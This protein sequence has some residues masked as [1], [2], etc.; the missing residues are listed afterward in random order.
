MPA[1]RTRDTQSRTLEVTT[2]APQP[3]ALHIVSPTPR[4]FTFPTSH[5]L[6][7]SPYSSPSN[8][9][10]EPDH[11]RSFPATCT[12]DST[13]STLPSPSTSTPPPSLFT[14]T[15]TPIVTDSPVTPTT[16]ASKR[17][18]STSS[19]SVDPA[20]RRPKKGDE[21]YVK[22]PENAFILFRRQCCEDRQA[23]LD[24]EPAGGVA[25]KKQRQAD[26][27][28]TISQ[29]W[30]SLSAGERKIW[31]DKAALKKREHEQLHPGYVYRPQRAKDKDG[32]ARNKKN[33]IA[34]AIA[35]SSTAGSE[36]GPA[37]KHEFEA[38]SLTFT[39][40][41]LRAPGSRSASMPT[42]PPYQTI[43][44]PNVYGFN[45]SCPTS[46]SLMPMISR[47]SAYPGFQ[48]PQPKD[49]VMDFDFV[50]NPSYVAPASFAMSSQFESNLQSSDFLR[51]MWNA[52]PS[53]M[54]HGVAPLHQFSF[55]NSAD[56]MHHQKP[57]SLLPAHQIISPSNS[58]GSTGSGSGSSG[59][60]SPANGPFT[61]I[62]AYT[63]SSHSAMSM[64]QL[65]LGFP[66][67]QQHQQTDDGSDAAALQAVAHAE[68]D[69][70]ME[71][72][73]QQEFAAFTWGGAWSGST[74]P[75]VLTDADF[76]IN[77]IPPLELGGPK[78]TESMALPLGGPGLEYGG[79]AQDYAHGQFHVDEGHGLMAFDD[80]MTGQTY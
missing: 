60:S 44:V 67:Q 30:K 42:P 16:P 46:P 7:D 53:N 38:E 79:G 69:R 19:G 61:P 41:M 58:I 68:M 4:A 37:K 32:R 74:E 48:P 73:L 13:L 22:R 75:A 50:P 57:T 47:R 23:L 78:Y 52:P 51:S 18:K 8:S 14:R 3:P 20:E 12:L 63:P 6:A 56:N 34:G 11:V 26:L 33:S 62:S 5:N 72:Q 54:H 80:M 66:S 21:D 25:A 71:M 2:D 39:I 76:D 17:R 45:T 27:S 43:Q 9:P 28:K 64:A 55:T 31:E 36:T 35:S 77:C 70:Q 15:L 24:G 59:P 49:N 65:G 40:P 29:Q 10:F 1:L